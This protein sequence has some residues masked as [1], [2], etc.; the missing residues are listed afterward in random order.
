MIAELSNLSTETLEK[1]HAALNEVTTELRG[2]M[3]FSEAVCNDAFFK[4]TSVEMAVFQA[5]KIKYLTKK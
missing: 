2:N 1:F 3:T 5:L 4:L